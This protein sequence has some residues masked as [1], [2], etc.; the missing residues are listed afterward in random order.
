VRLTNVLAPHLVAARH[1]VDRAVY[2]TVSVIAVIAGASHGDTSAG[3]LLVFTAVSSLVVWGVHVYSS[4]LAD[5]GPAGLAWSPALRKA[6]VEERGVLGGVVIPLGILALGALDVVDDQRA[7]YA[8]M[9]SG[10]VVLFVTPLVWLQPR[11]AGWAGCLLASF[12]GGAL[13]LVLIWFKVV[14][15]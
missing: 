1:T 9:W 11:G 3:S 7:I 13:G 14:L 6:L 4:V 15:H 12:A 2:G 8:S 5:T 10:V